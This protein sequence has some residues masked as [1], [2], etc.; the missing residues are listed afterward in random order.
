MILS[1]V[2][3]CRFFPTEIAAGQAPKQGVLAARRVSPLHTSAPGHWSLNVFC[4]CFFVKAGHRSCPV[5]RASAFLVSCGKG[6]P[7]VYWCRDGQDVCRAGTCRGFWLALV[8]CSL[9]SSLCFP[10]ALV[11]LLDNS[12]PRSSLLSLPFLYIACPAPYLQSEVWGRCPSSPK[13]VS[14]NRGIDCL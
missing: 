2:P 14:H 11:L 7:G 12:C 13:Y 9:P 10:W 3:I 4:M 5:S 8:L 6:E 1:E